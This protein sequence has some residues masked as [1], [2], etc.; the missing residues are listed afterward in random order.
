MEMDIR[1]VMEKLP[2]RFPFLMVDRIISIIPGKEIEG[3]KNVS[4][5]EPFF[6]GHFPQSPVMPGVLILEA[7]AQ[8]GGILALQV[9]EQN[10]AGGVVYLMGIDRVRFRKPVIPGDQLR[11]RLR[12]MRQKG[13]VFRLKG[14][15]FVEDDLV[16]EG[17]FLATLQDKKTND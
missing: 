14:E 3:I 9:I 8:V 17:E 2:H 11:L 5:N 10:M 16:A 15:A 4:I 13:F 12:I 1:E 6:Q 7:M